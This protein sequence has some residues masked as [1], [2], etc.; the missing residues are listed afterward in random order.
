M[1]DQSFCCR[2][3]MRYTGWFHEGCPKQPVFQ[4]QRERIVC[5][6]IRAER[7]RPM[8]HRERSASW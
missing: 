3:G 4:E 2:C 1:E 6:E 5:A 7:G 8:K